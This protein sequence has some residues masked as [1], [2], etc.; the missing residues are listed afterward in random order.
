MSENLQKYAVSVD[1]DA[2]I[3]KIKKLKA[4]TDS[5]NNAQAVAQRQQLF[6]HRTYNKRIMSDSDKRMKESSANIGNMFKEARAHADNFYANEEKALTKKK[7][8]ALANEKLVAKAIEKRQKAEH[9]RELDL[10]K[11]A[12]NKKKN[13]LSGEKQIAEARRRNAVSKLTASTGADG[14]RSY[15]KD[16]EKQ[17][18]KKPTARESFVGP[19]PNKTVLNQYKNEAKAA[20]SLAK[21]RR[22]LELILKLRAGVASRAE[23]EHIAQTLTA[24][25][26]AKTKESLSRIYKTHQAN[27]KE[28]SKQG[29]LM[30]RMNSSSKQLAGNMISAFAIAAGA[31]SIVQ[32]GQELQSVDNTMLAVSSSAEESGENLKFVKE[33]A[34]R[35]GLSLKESS[36]GFAKMVSARGDMSLDEVKASF[37]GLSE[38]STLLG[39]SSEESGRAVNALQQMMSK[40]TVTA[41]ELK[42]QMGEVLPN[43][44]QLMAKAAQDAGLSTN[45]TVKEM[46]ALQQSGSLVSSKVLPFFA[47][48]MHEAAIA[49]G[50][51]KEALK[52]NRVA[53]GQM[54]FSYT[55]AANTI[56]K[57]GFEE[58][59]T[60]LFKS[61]GKLLKDNKDLWKTFGKV[62]GGLLKGLSVGID[63]LSAVLQGFGWA[64]KTVTDIFGSLHW[65]LQGL[66]GLGALATLTTMF[67]TL[68]LGA[69]AA[70]FPVTALTAQI[71]L[72]GSAIGVVLALIQ[73][74]WMYFSDDGAKTLTGESIKYITR[75][76]NELTESVK[77]AINWVKE[78]F[79]LTGNDV[80]V[81]TNSTT[82]TKGGGGYTTKPAYTGMFNYGHSDFNTAARQ[83]M[84]TVNVQV[85]GETLAKVVV[86]SNQHTESVSNQINSASE[87]SF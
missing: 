49:N 60:K 8:E 76:F 11:I 62:V 70:L 47:K 22:E 48:R 20:A 78:L 38:M 33:E 30:S 85:D 39:L 2:A 44:L 37:T 34:Y 28:L 73:D 46:Y 58:G 16:L 86:S 42:Q 82:T 65:T 25:K 63:V 79:G 23:K 26:V 59:L 61:T 15:Y 7:D 68:K 45:G 81:N 72:W 17:S 9:Q 32:V 56:F 52:S 6:A 66:V 1:F 3:S 74:V 50:G 5:L 27:T 18:N 4:I 55:Q 13:L 12:Y 19:L 83:G 84:Q 31:K 54:V 69:V 75:T 35:L 87:A 29:F 53:M 71:V 51:L 40:G 36:K 24:M 43:S 80:T 77:A 14:M 10:A 57:S 41:E 67:K 64:L 21:R